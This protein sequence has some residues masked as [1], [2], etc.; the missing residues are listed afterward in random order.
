M[1]WHLSNVSYQPQ[2]VANKFPLILFKIYK[3]PK[4]KVLNNQSLLSFWN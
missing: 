4:V 3:A 2:D 1:E